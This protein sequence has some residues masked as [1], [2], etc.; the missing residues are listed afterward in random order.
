MSKTELNVWE[1]LA[2]A[3]PHFATKWNQTQTENS[4]YGRTKISQKNFLSQ[5]F[6]RFHLELKAS[7]LPRSFSD[8][9]FIDD[10]FN[11]CFHV[12]KRK[13]F[14]EMF[15]LLCIWV[16]NTPTSWLKYLFGAFSYIF[17][18]FRCIFTKNHNNR[19]KQDRFTTCF[20]TCGTGFLILWVGAGSQYFGAKAA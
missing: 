5:D 2:F 10:C 1:K 12:H 13:Q 4:Q 11:W 6:N 20:K 18:V 17:L 7:V 14:H 19:L 16:A 15:Q 9:L 8:P 3:A